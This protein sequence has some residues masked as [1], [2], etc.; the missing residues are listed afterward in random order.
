MLGFNGGLVGR[1]RLATNATLGA[2][3]LWLP[4]EQNV[5]KR[6]SR[7]PLGPV[8]LPNIGDAYAGGFFAGFI[9]HTANGVATHL[10]VA[11]PL[12]TGRSGTGYTLTTNLLYKTTNSTVANGF[13][14]FDG[15]LNTDQL[16][17]AGIATYP[18]AQFC[19]NLNIGGFTD[20]YLPSRFEMEIIY[21]NLKPGTTANQTG[22]GLTSAVNA[23]AVPPRAGQYTAGNPAQ[24]TVA[25]FIAAGAQAFAVANH[26]TSTSQSGFNRTQNHSFN[27]GGSSFDEVT[28]ASTRTLAIRRVAI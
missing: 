21:T 1:E 4:N 15:R 5:A 20:W 24:T 28:T 10:L 17:A 12:G 27:N 8:E 25:A 16:I 6:A 2:S 19:V 9:S 3:G 13:S 7:W 22:V 11:A 14:T 23:Y 26:W 18:A